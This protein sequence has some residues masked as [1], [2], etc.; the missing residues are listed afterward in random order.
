MKLLSKGNTKLAKEVGTFSILANMEICG[1]ECP[2]CYAIKEQNGRFKAT[3][4]QGRTLRYNISKGDQFVNAMVKEIL[5]SRTFKYIRL[6]GSGE[7][8][9]QEYI[10]K[11]IEIAKKVYEIKPEIVFYTYT[12]TT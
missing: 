6:H 4:N 8:Y 12:K 1:R 5:G 10:N 3:V 11:W 7:F 2:G 9:S